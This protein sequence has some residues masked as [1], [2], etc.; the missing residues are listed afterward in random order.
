MGE[1]YEW[2]QQTIF[3]SSLLT[4]MLAQGLILAYLVSFIYSFCSKMSVRKSKNEHSES[5]SSL[6]DIFGEKDD[7]ENLAVGKSPEAKDILDR[8]M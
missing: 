8:E 6:H 7:S 1:A 2:R 3:I 4:G 5:I